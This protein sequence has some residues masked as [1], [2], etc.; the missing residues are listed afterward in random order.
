MMRLP[1]ALVAAIMMNCSFA[2]DFATQAVEATHK[3][4]NKDSTATGIFI[5]PPASLN[6]PG[7][8]CW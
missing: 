2:A 7:K 3:L 5:L 6:Q 8:L 4:F 1:A